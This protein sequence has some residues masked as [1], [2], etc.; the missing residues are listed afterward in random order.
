MSTYRYYQEARD[1]AW[2]ALLRLK[3]KRLPV[4]A[5]ALAKEVGMEVL[6]FPSPEE[7]PRLWAL[8]E[9]AA[10]GKGVSLRIKGTWHIFLRENLLM[11]DRRRFAVA[12]E[13][14][15]LLLG[16]ETR[17]IAPGVRAFESRENEGDLMEDPQ[18]LAD[19]AADIF[20]IRLLAPACLLHELHVDTPGGIMAL[21]ALPPRAA[22][23]RAERMDLLNERDAFY[24]NT[25][26][27]Q[28]RDAFLPY[29]RARQA[30]VPAA[31]SA[32]ARKIPLAIPPKTEAA[33]EGQAVRA[34][35]KA[36]KPQERPEGRP[37]RR[38]RLVGAGL[39]FAAALI[40]FLLRD[41][42]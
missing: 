33:P 22:A 21:C 40:F 2:R 19:Y 14:G 28:V 17:A 15:H 23:L 30:A 37:S 9:K 10:G 18:D 25:L 32:P 16:H 36:G 34:P 41:G 38:W 20:A 5:E 3:E 11:G 26:E 13:L 1:T 39:V 12:H 4:D 27:A 29:L 6:P 35:S 8:L 7:N 42:G 31:P 24:T